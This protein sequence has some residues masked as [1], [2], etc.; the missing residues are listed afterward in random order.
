MNV[1]CQFNRQVFWFGSCPTLWRSGRAVGLWTG[2]LV[3]SCFFSFASL[4]LWSLECCH[5]GWS[6]VWTIWRFWL[7]LSLAWMSALPLPLSTRSS[8][9]ICPFY[10]FYFF[11]PAR[12]VRQISDPLIE[13]SS[14]CV[15]SLRTYYCSI[16]NPC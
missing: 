15:K 16:L 4:L 13:S 8:Q 2:R 14:N 11:V 10:C 9:Q 6:Q 12:K 3:G 5:G 7:G 1:N